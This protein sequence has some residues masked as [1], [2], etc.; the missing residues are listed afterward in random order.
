M[1]LSK[2]TYLMGILNVTPDSF[3]DGGKYFDQQKAVEAAFRM[4]E[5]GADIIDIGG[6]SSRP[7]ARAV[8]AKEEWKRI[9][10]VIACLA[11]KIKVPISV[12]T[13]KVE[14]ARR[15][16]DAGAAILN[17]IT[18]LRGKNNMAEL[19]AKTEAGL[20]I[21]HMKGMP[22]TMQKNPEYGDLIGEIRA[23]LKKSIV[24]ARAAGVDSDRI[25][26]DPGIGFGK[27]LEHNLEIL[28]YLSEFS[29]GYPVL[30]GPSRKSFIGGI[31]DLPADQR[32]EGTAAAV[33]VSILNGAKIV[34]VHDVREMKRVAKICD[35]ILKAK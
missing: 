33:A 23:F 18:G 9:G 3:S 8:N 2:K 13:Y 10:P 5:E 14:V 21:M 1:D 20:V 6:E 16:F 24:I 31:L 30:V 17:D 7:G 4:I 12:D 28:K 32:L 15:A 34:R 19:V 29:F 11:G 26:I 27:T 25:A 35:A 22:R